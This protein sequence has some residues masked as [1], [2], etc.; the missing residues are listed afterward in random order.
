VVPLHLAQRPTLLP[1]PKKNDSSAAALAGLSEPCAALR[2]PSLP[3]SARMLPGAC[4]RAVLLS[5]GPAHCKH[6]ESH[7]KEQTMASV[8]LTQRLEL[9]ELQA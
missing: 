6:H 3:N 5:V 2:V 7:V 1:L 9:N 4:C 8:T